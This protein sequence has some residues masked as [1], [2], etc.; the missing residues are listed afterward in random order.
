MFN[1]GSYRDLINLIMFYTYDEFRRG[2]S[3]RL[4]EH[5]ETDLKQA[6][7]LAQ[8]NKVSYP[9]AEGIYRNRPDLINDAIKL[10]IMKGR[11]NSIL[12][13]ET[14]KFLALLSEQKEIDI[15][16]IKTFKG[17]P[18][19][20]QDVDILVK[21]EHWRRLL[22]LLKEDKCVKINHGH[23][24]FRALNKSNEY[25]FKKDRL[26]TID[27]YQDFSWFGSDIVSESFIWE[28]PRSYNIGSER[29]CRIPNP[30]ADLMTIMEHDLFWDGKFSLLDLRYI[31]TLLKGEIRHAELI[32]E[33][34]D[35]GWCRA[36]KKLLEEIRRVNEILNKGDGSIRLPYLVP[37]RLI[38]SAYLG[39][40]GNLGAKISPMARLTVIC[41]CLLHNGVIL[42][43]SLLRR[44]KEGFL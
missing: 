42:R 11:A 20:T 5:P 35:N 40:V 36:Y 10:E 6:L 38:S 33:S 8:L 26:L 27:L 31:D 41:R 4:N 25:S 13:N 39:H 14:L 16:V 30:D 15:L 34:K 23:M 2:Y 21:K 17:I 44:L 24:F 1:E 19:I 9:F 22:A 32:K 43:Y 28:N 3:G 7:K 37:I 12:L 29:F 18:Y